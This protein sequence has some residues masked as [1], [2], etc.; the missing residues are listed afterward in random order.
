MT[1]STTEQAALEDRVM[2]SKL[3]PEEREWQ[4]TVWWPAALACLRDAADATNAA[5]GTST[6]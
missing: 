2:G 6:R 1:P 5:A 3:T 4:L